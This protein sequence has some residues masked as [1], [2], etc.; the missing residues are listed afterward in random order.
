MSTSAF[1]NPQRSSGRCARWDSDRSIGDTFRASRT[2]SGSRRSRISAFTGAPAGSGCCPGMRS[3]ACSTG[4]YGSARTRSDGPPTDR[5]RFS[6]ETNH[7]TLATALIQHDTIPPGRALSPRPARR[8]SAGPLLLYALFAAFY[9]LPFAS[10]Q[11]VESPAG[12]LSAHLSGIV[13]ARNAI[14]EGQIP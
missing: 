10:K 11:V 5:G 4:G 12:D 2:S 3:R 6:A 7:Y 13:E 9:V 14:R 1:T 8:G